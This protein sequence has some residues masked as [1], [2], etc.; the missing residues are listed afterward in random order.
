MDE[1]EDG[2]GHSG[3]LVVAEIEDGQMRKTQWKIKWDL[4]YEVEGEVEAGMEA[5]LVQDRGR[6]LAEKVRVVPQCPSQEMLMV[7]LLAELRSSD[8]GLGQLTVGQRCGA[9]AAHYYQLKDISENNNSCLSNHILLVGS[10]HD[11][12]IFHTID[13]Q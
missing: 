2:L 6:D 7:E 13:N 4:F 11:F 5:D 12:E 1:A 3:D 8:V 9:T 10:R